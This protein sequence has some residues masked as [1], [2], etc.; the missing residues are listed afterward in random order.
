MTSTRMTVKGLTPLFL[1]S[2]SSFPGEKEGRENK[3]G[4]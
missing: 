4:V 1:Y 3:E 2:G